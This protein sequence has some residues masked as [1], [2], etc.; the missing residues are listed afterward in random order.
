MQYL[1]YVTNIKVIKYAYFTLLFKPSVVK[2]LRYD[3]FYAYI[4]LSI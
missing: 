4:I 1:K 3:L 2:Y